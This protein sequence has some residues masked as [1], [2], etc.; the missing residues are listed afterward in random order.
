VILGERGAHGPL[1]KQDNPLN[2]WFTKE[3]EEAYKISPASASAY[4]IVQS[5]LGLKIAVEKAAE[6][7]GGQ[8]PNSEQI[9][10]AMENLEWETPSGTIKMAL[11]NGHQAIQDAAVGV[12]KWDAE[13][14]RMTV[15]D[16]RYYP[17]HCINPPAD[18]TSA[19]WIEAG[20][21][22]PDDCK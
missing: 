3:Y 13:N 16:V 22:V 2:Q 20:L 19:E 7:N 9:A 17:A 21:P 8:K 6:A 1:A 15:T 5:I 12:T 14:N 18:M 4:R 10:A 11:A